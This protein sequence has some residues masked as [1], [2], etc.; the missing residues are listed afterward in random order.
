MAAKN[1]PLMV[2]GIVGAIVL[3]LLLLVFLLRGTGDN[4]N[5]IVD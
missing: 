1:Q 4:A 2:S 3:V 5:L